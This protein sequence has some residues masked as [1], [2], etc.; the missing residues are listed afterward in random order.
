MS[1]VSRGSRSGILPAMAAKKGEHAIVEVCGHELRVS[2]PGKV[3]FPERGPDQAR[4]RQLLRRVRAGRRAPPARAPDGD[5]ALGRRGP[6]QAVLPEARA[7][8]R[9]RVA[10]DRHR[11]LPQRPPRARARAQRRRPPRLGGQPR[12]DRLE[13][14]AGAPRR[15]R[16]SRRA[17]RRPRPLPGRAVRGGARGGAGRARGAR[18]ARP[19]RL[20]QDLGLARASTSTCGSSPS[21]GFE[22]VRR[23]ALAL[24]REVERRMPGRATSRWWKEEREGVFIDYNQNARDRTVASA[25]SVRAVADARVSC[26]LEWE[27]VADVEPAELTPA[28]RSPRACASAATPRPTIDEHAGRLD[29]P[30][31][32][33]RA[34]RARGPRRRALAAAL[35]QAEGRAA[36]RAAEPGPR[37]ASRAA[38]TPAAQPPLKP[39]L[40]L[41]RK[42]L[43]D[44]RG[45]LATRSSS[46]AFAAWRSWTARRSSCSRATASRSGATSPSW[47]SPPGATC[48]TARSS[49][50]TA[51]GREDFDALGQR[52]HPAASRDRAPV[53]R[54]ARR[55]RGVRPAR[56]RG[57]VA[58]RA[59]LRRAP[60]GA[61]GAAR[62]A[63]AFAAAPVELMQT[64]DDAEE[65]AALAARR[66]GGDRQG[67]LRALPPG[68]AQ[69]HGQGQAR[70]H[71]RRGRGRLAPR[72]GAGHRRRADPRPLRR[73]ASC[74]WWGTARASAPPRSAARRLPRAL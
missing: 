20:P 25:Y 24:A 7:R 8:Q 37:A 74:A 16:P 49:C 6:G 65:A 57:R 61:R 31:R 17:A 10:A 71:D 32:A 67:A 42:E 69:G 39:Q 44:G 60:R 43:P 50:A 36:A 26:P 1:T 22:E 40:A 14:V 52:I 41:S 33:G 4:P 53:R 62:A 48:S 35:P 68:R 23:A 38:M 12:R 73:R 11:H 19:A 59:P 15:P 18:G 46:T 63:S 5:E 34:R 51:D 72:Q 54:D 55:V 45:V 47:C 56:P 58:A 66:R 3:F 9:A 64:A 2:N 21:E 28:R 70:A 29:A 13:P 27:E 30:A